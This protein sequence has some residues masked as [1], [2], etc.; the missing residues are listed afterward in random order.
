MSQSAMPVL[1]GAVIP[2]VLP[3]VMPDVPAVPQMLPAQLPELALP[4]LLPADLPFAGRAALA[5]ALAGTLPGGRPE[6]GELARAAGRACWDEGECARLRR[7]LDAV[8]DTRARRGRE[9]PLRYLLALPLVAGMAGDGELDAA[10]E[11][12]ASAPE[13][14]LLRL[15]APLDRSG[16]PPAGRD[17]ARPDPGRCRSVPVRRRAVLLDRRPRPRAA[18]WPAQAP[19]GRREGA[20][21]RGPAGRTGADAAVRDLGRRHHRR[22]AA[23]WTSSPTRSRSS[24]NC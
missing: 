5:A 17:H 19:A 12:I 16:R 15:G 7:F 24:G 20:A 14:V 6:R 2:E 22:P 10:G 1:S 9:Y 11:W 4:A 23:R 13:E 21:R 18:P 8:G 3:A